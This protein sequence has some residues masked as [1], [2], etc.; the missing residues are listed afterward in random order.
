MAVRHFMYVRDTFGSWCQSTGNTRIST[1]FDQNIQDEGQMT[2]LTCVYHI[3]CLALV[4]E[5]AR[6]YFSQ[7]AV[8]ENVMIF[9]IVYFAGDTCFFDKEL[10]RPVFRIFMPPDGSG[11]YFLDAIFRTSSG[12]PPC[13]IIFLKIRCE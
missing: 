5:E 8:V 12:G 13:G 9:F 11:Y 2:V 1:Y 3:R 10:S 7:L 4:V 6:N